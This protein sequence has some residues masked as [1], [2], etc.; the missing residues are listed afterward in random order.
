MDSIRSTL[1]QLRGYHEPWM[2]CKPWRE[3]RI[4]SH[5][6][7]GCFFALAIPFFGLPAL[8]SSTVALFHLI[9]SGRILW[10]AM[11][12]AT[13]FGGGVA[14]VSYFWRHWSKFGKSVC[15]L[16]TLPGVIGGWFK[17][18]VE[19]KI[20]GHPPPSLLV[21]LENYKIVGMRPAIRLTA[22]ETS[23]HVPPSQMKR[24]KGNKYLIQV[25][26]QIP[27]GK[28]YYE[29]WCW[30]LNQNSPEST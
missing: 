3:R 20:P 1:A 2:A 27:S 11:I 22:W 29:N 16:E 7:R 10:E 6:V 23:K 15:Y 21:R 5:G 12:P 8:L 14:A 30:L 4:E 9:G 19:F 18:S 17:A 24:L 28:D 13:I 26:F 25:C